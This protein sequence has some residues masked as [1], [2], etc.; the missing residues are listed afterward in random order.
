MTMQSGIWGTIYCSLGVAAIT[1]TALLVSS[2]DTGSRSLGLA[3]ISLCIATFGSANF[4]AQARWL[5]TG[6][7]SL[8]A[9]RT[10]L[11]ADRDRVHHDEIDV[12]AK[13]ALVDYEALRA[14]RAIEERQEFLLAQIDAE[15]E[16]MLAEVDDRKNFYRSEGF[17]SGFGVGVRGVAAE[18]PTE[19]ATVIHL[20]VGDQRPTTMGQG[21]ITS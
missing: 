12:A 6:R 15:R 20:P 13:R 10:E 14:T 7:A 9:G 3:G 18:T 17:Q 11:D 19:G 2:F 4:V 8:D 21:A 16:K 1:T 5:K